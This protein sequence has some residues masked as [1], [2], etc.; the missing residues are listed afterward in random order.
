M[1]NKL[2]EKIKQVV[3]LDEKKA[4]SE[5]C[6]SIFYVHKPYNYGILDRIS[7][8]MGIDNIILGI[9]KKVYKYAEIYDNYISFNKDKLSMFK[10]CSN[11][12][13]IYFESETLNSEATLLSVYETIESDIGVLFPSYMIANVFYHPLQDK[14]VSDKFF[15][16]KEE[17]MELLK[18][19][20]FL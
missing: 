4:G 10:R 11:D 8:Q 3:L 16:C 14:L 17:E 2:D 18:N 20:R 5:F 12:T 15:Y 19:V 9:V 13:K 6:S 1:M 7:F